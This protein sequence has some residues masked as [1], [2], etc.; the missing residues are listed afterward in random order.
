VIVVQ[1]LKPRVHL[2]DGLNFG[3][4]ELLKYVM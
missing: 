3:E 1:C 2:E 4:S